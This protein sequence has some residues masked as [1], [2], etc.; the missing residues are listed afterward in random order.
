MVD[1]SL[2]P[3]ATLPALLAARARAATD[4]RLALDVVGGMCAAAVL[5][6]WHPAGWVI[7][8]SIAVCLAAFGVWGITDREII[9]RAAHTA[10]G[11]PRLV[12]TLRVLRVLAT[13]TGTA[14]AILACF[15]LLRLTLGTWIS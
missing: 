10:G 11:A 9:E 6:V 5:A 1:S 14:A 8:C 13:V 7:P 15:A 2:A 4:G 12:S 3:D